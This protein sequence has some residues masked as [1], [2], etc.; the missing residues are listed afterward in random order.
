ME[1]EL[2]IIV[3]DVPGASVEGREVIKIDDNTR[4]NSY[5]CFSVHPDILA[6]V[7]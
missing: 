2:E 6:G 4:F 5:A 1:E 3:R 7:D